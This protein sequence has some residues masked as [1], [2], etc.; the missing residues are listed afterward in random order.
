MVI[1]VFMFSY[2]VS[3]HTYTL[4]TDTNY[5]IACQYD[6]TKFSLHVSTLRILTIDFISL[7]IKAKM[8]KIVFYI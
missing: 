4:H 8:C 6:Y 7:K 2:H 5:G 3:R 1:N